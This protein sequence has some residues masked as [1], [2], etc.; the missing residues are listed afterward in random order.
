[1]NPITIFCFIAW[2]RKCAA[3]FMLHVSAEIWRVKRGVRALV[4]PVSILVNRTL[5]LPTERL[6]PYERFRV[7]RM[8]GGISTPPQATIH[9]PEPTART[10]TCR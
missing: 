2:V 4:L 3:A 10:R 1:V 7:V 5:T 6:M 8:G 9:C